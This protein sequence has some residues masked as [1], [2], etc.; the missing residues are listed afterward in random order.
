M[1]LHPSKPLAYL[2][3]LDTNRIALVHGFATR[4]EPDASALLPAPS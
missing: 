2:S 1:T 3:L 4:S